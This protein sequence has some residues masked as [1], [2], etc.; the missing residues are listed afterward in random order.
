MRVRALRPLLVLAAVL[1][2]LLAVPA[3]AEPVAAPPLPGPEHRGDFPDPHVLRVGQDFYAYSTTTGGRHLPVL[4][5]GDL[6]TWTGVL[7][8]GP[9]LGDALPRPAMWSTDREGGIAKETWAPAVTRLG[10]RYVAYYAV[11]VA[12][13][14]RFC[15][16]VATALAPA[17]PFVDATTEPLVCDADPGGS[18]DPF[19]YVDPAT[20][21]A[22]LAWK[23]EGHPG[24]A[25]QRLLARELQPGGLAF[26]AGSRVRELL[27]P[28][29]AWEADVVENPGMISHR[30]RWYLFYSGNRWDSADYAEG[31]AVCRTPLGPCTRQGRGPLMRSSG[32]QLG[33]A[34]ASPF[35]DAAGGLRLAYHWWPA[36]HSSYARGAVRHLGITAVQVS[37][38]GRLKVSG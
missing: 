30:G 14:H 33:R 37:R 35:V 27:R 28:G 23:A 20:G 5:S 3:G 13:P 29:R 25:P 6:R 22:Y 4:R 1:A 8:H 17:G 7:A 10:D 32:K 12:L 16:S 15:I 2:G 34:G 38:D 21:R 24:R 9:A 18:I 11:R 19:P 31:V 36:P 26:A